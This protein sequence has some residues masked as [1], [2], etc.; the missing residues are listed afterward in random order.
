MHF[1]KKNFR[2]EKNLPFE[3]RASLWAY[4]VI[5]SCS[6]LKKGG[7]ICFVL[8]QIAMHTLYGERAISLIAKRFA[9]VHW[10][11]IRNRHFEHEGIDEKVGILHAKN[12]KPDGDENESDI[13][14]IKVF[15]ID[16]KDFDIIER[17]HEREDVPTDIRIN[18]ISLKELY[19]KDD[20][21]RLGELIDIKIGTVTGDNNYFVID[22]ITRNK[23][24][25]RED[26]FIPIIRKYTHCGFFNF[27]RSDWEKLASENER[28]FLFY[29]NTIDNSD[30]NLQC[31]LDS[32]PAEKKKTNRTFEKRSYWWQVDIG[33]YPDAFFPYMNQSGPSL[34]LNSANAQCTN[35]IHKIFFNNDI[36]E[37]QKNLICLALNTTIAKLSGELEG[38]VYS[39]GVL[40]FEPSAVRKIFIPNILKIQETD[41]TSKNISDIKDSYHLDSDLFRRRVDN[42]FLIKNNKLAEDFLS[43]LRKN[44]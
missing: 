26:Y 39:S 34:V 13:S 9:S 28:V 37:L 29:P 44:E 43:K 5:H 12:Y 21:I 3:N 7:S 10:Y 16:H 4:F 40:K 27:T 30:P 33:S 23:N 42:F 8:P 1:E 35:N 19:P 38:R 6:F 31:Y 22:E 18:K 32:Y 15:S 2:K 24:N 17:I 11:T 20:L 41:Q 25:L 14:D 36:N